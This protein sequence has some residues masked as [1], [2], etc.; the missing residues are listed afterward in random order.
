MENQRFE[1]ILDK[2]YNNPKHPASFSSPYKLWIAAHKKNVKISLEFVK[3]WLQSQNSYTLHREVRREFPRRKVIVSGVGIQYQADLVD[4]APIKKENLGYRY[5]LTMIDCFSRKAIAIPMKSKTAES[6]ISALKKA[7]KFLGAPQKLQT[8]QGSE[9]FAEKVKRYF[10]D[11]VR[12]KHFHSKS[13][14]KASI[15]ERF[16][17]TLRSKIVKYM[18]AKESLTYVGALPDIIEGYNASVHSALEKYSPNDVNKRNEKEIF[19]IQYRE[20]LN[21]RKANRKFQIGDSVRIATSRTPFKKGHHR[22]FSVELYEVVDTLN[23]QPNTYRVKN[24]SKSTAVE[25]MFYEEQLQKAKPKSQTFSKRI[26]T[27]PAFGFPMQM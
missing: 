16:N 26:A 19:E 25:G 3:E 10:K 20:Y 9:F 18:V 8:D 4:F 15:V 17:R 6:S 22:N 1:N 11:T 2:I 14:M 21:K 12:I 5:L 23:T 7:F 27:H 24:Q 13:K